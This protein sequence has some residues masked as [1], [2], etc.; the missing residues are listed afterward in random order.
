MIKIRV[1]ASIPLAVR[2]DSRCRPIMVFEVA[3]TDETNERKAWRA[4]SRLARHARRL[5]YIID[6][7]AHKDGSGEN[8]VVFV[9]LERVHGARRGFYGYKKILGENK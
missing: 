4:C 6:R 3:Q 1:F 8:W 5:S 2:S 7:K 9:Q